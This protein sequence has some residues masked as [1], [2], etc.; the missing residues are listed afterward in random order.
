[1]A[2]RSARVLGMLLI[3]FENDFVIPLRH[4]RQGGHGLQRGRISLQTAR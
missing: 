2:R 3:P 1:M 4:L